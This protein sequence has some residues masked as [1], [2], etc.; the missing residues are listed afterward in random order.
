MVTKARIDRLRVRTLARITALRAEYFEWWA[1][2]SDEELKK[3]VS[4]DEEAMK[5]LRMRGGD[6][7]SEMADL[8]LTPD[9]KREL[10]Q[11]KKELKHAQ[12]QPK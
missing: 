3:V 6:R 10:A 8:V 5:L 1:Q 11:V 4:G 2:F 9:E 12:D 7:I